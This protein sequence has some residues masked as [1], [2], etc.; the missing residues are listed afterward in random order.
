VVEGDVDSRGTG[1]DA[2]GRDTH[3]DIT[4][5]VWCAWGGGIMHPLC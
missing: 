1:L 3:I 5:M 2:G 4:V